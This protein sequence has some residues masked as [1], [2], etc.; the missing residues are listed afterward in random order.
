MQARCNHAWI[1]GAGLWLAVALIRVMASSIRIG[2]RWRWLMKRCE[3]SWRRAAIPA[4]PGFWTIFVG[5]IRSCP[6]VWAAWFERRRVV[7]M[8][9]WPSERRLSPARIRSTTNTATLKA[10]ALRFRRRCSFRRSHWFPMCCTPFRWTQK[11]RA[12]RYIS[13]AK[14]AQNSAARP[15]ATLLLGRTTGR[16]RRLIWRWLPP[17]TA[18]FTRQLPLAW[19]ALAT[20]SAKADL[21]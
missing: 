12:T 10:T 2:W 7:T 11:R 19:F 18:P 21:A 20:I 16:C 8:R 4:K 1:R 15:S 14:L 9:R 17:S 3:T 6:T 13:S 5:A